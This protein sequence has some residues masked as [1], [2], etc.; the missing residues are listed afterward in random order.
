MSRA[1][2]TRNGLN[3]DAAS[4]VVGDHPMGSAT[5]AFAIG[6]DEMA[7]R[8]WQQ[9]QLYR[10]GRYWKVRYYED[11][12]DGDSG[13]LKRRKARPINIG[14]CEGVGRLTEKQALKR[15]A[16]IM[17]EVNE[18]SHHPQSLMTIRELVDRKFRPQHIVL[19][20]PA[21]QKHYEH[22][23][24][25]HIMPALGDLALRDL[26]A[27][28]VRGLIAAKSRHYSR[29]T[30]KHVRTVLRTVIDFAKEGGHF[31]GENPAAV[32]I[33]LPDA[34][35][36]R[37]QA[38]TWQEARLILDH[39]PSPVHEMAFLSATVS[40]NV[41]ELCG[42]RVGRVNFK[43][44]PALIDGELAPGYSVA[45][46]ENYYEGEYGTLKNG[47]RRRNVPI[48]PTLLPKLEALCGGKQ[49]HHALFSNS[50]GV[51]PI[52]AHNVSNRLFKKLSAKLGIKVNWHRFRHS[53]ATFSNEIGMEM[54]D[55]QA[56]GAWAT[57]SMAAHYTHPF[58]RQQTGASVI[59]EKLLESAGT[60]Q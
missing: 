15:K 22:I 47:K 60:V 57:E 27:D 19:C 55:R 29:Q 59:A 6:G 20:K 31:T 46:R 2:E 3:I 14:P 58:E 35:P 5:L 25:S 42:I 34:E 9:G 41:A 38:Y 45:I 12:I 40:C 54:A 17:R 10:E 13:Q 28:M 53:H 33:R 56:M 52:D 48:P 39:L 32:K 51:K 23:L 24:R 16:E 36:Q 26:T 18:D 11:Y 4:R 44:T 49:D 8:R 30:L 21:G 37:I 43:S 1:L 7:R 50:G